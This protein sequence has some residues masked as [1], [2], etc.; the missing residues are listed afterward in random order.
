MLWR[1]FWG[2]KANISHELSALKQEL[3]PRQVL[4]PGLR[5]ISPG[6]RPFVMQ[7]KRSHRYAGLAIRICPRLEGITMDYKSIDAFAKRPVSVTLDQVRVPQPFFSRR[8]GKSF[9]SDNWLAE[10][11]GH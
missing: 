10:D 2:Q 6:L 7:A 11:V 4:M 9:R 3:A 5:L 1:V 8:S